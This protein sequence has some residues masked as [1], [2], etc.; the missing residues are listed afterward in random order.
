MN[1]I[2]LISQGLSPI[3]VKE[4]LAKIF[5]NLKLKKAV[6]ITTASRD[7]E[8][9]KWNIVTQNEFLDM[10]F[11]SADFLDLETDQN[12]DLSNYSVVYVAGGNTFKLMKYVGESN[13]KQEVVNLLNRGGVYIGSSA[14]AI[15]ATPTIKIA[16]EITPDENSVNLTNLEGMGLVDFEVLPHFEKSLNIELENY[17]NKTKNDVKT[18]SNEGVIVV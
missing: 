9:N 15:I 10:G 12:I 17:K 7:K 2:V 1:Q 4:A 6:I 5:S 13:F 16:G 18:I 14:G 8:K 3:L 11:E